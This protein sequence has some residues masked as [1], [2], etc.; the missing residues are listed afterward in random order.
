VVHGWFKEPAVFFTG[1]LQPEVRDGL[2]R[3]SHHSARRLSLL[4]CSRAPLQEAAET[5][6]AALDILYE[7]L[8]ALG[9]AL[10]TVAARVHV[11]AD[12]A[13]EG[14]KLLT[15][16]L[17][18]HPCNEDRGAVRQA[19]LSVIV[20]SLQDSAFPAAAADS[21]I[22]VP[23]VF[24][25]QVCSQPCPPPALVDCIAAWYVGSCGENICWTCNA[26]LHGLTG[27]TGR[28]C[29][30]CG[31]VAQKFDTARAIH[32]G[33]CW[34]RSCKHQNVHCTTLRT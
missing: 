17:V 22:T 3:V 21:H 6:N 29:W 23:F 2:G 11:G 19:I 8:D 9:P 10:G 1:A 25:V 32:R 18:A 15:D 13:V 14:V 33:I 7:R 26:P 27:L 16:T 28:C 31:C 24:Q 5:L 12:G 20:R 30:G 4:T 34:V